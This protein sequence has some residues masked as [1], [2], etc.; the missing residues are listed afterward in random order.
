VQHP[1]AALQD[2]Y[3]RLFRS[4]RIL[5]GRRAMLESRA[6]VILKHSEEHREEWAQVTEATG[7]PML[8]GLASFER[9]CDCDYSCSPAQGDPWR[10]VS[11]HVPL[12]L[13]P[14]K[15]WG[16]SCVAA[17]RIDHLEAVGEGNW[18]WARAAYESEAFNGFGPRNHGRHSGYPWAWTTIYDGGK[19]V[20]DGKWDSGAYDQQ[21]GT[22]AMMVA[23]LTLDE[24]LAFADACPIPGFK[25][26]DPVPAPSGVDGGADGTVWLQTTLNRFGTQPPLAV[27]GNYGRATR[28]AVRDFQAAHHLVADGLAGPETIAVLKGLS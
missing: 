27:D 28:R 22:V 15:S 3:V 13:G 24:S 16:A 1:F 11:I 23:L 18:T 14:Y 4:C 10:R 25:D 7:V 6:R 21:C 5:P 17:Y 8:W 12:G 9:E 26:V 19:Y 2:E 20:A